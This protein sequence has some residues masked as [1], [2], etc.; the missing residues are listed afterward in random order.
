MNQELVEL[1]ST[2]LDDALFEVPSDY[3]QV[4]LEALLKGSASAPALPQ[5]KQ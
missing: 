2:P 5:F 1:S 3:Q 4:S